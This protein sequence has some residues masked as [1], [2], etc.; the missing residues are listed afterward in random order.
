MADV[1][2]ASSGCSGGDFDGEV[3]F[4]VGGT[5]NRVP[6]S[7]IRTDTFAQVDGAQSVISSIA[8]RPSA[9]CARPWPHRRWGRG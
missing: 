7:Q 4:E 8:A 5:G 9:A 2:E 1:E 3:A 6:L